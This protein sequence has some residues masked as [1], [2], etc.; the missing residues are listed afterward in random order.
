MAAQ[1]TTRYRFTSP[2]S[3][4]ISPPEN[5]TPELSKT[6]TVR[7]DQPSTA[8]NKDYVGINIHVYDPT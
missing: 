8:L 3:T 2:V 6:F 7:E 1:S 5:P 4:K